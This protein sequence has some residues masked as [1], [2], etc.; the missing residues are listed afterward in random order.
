MAERLEEGG[1]SRVVERWRG[2][3]GLGKGE[4]DP[5]TPAGR[6]RTSPC[7]VPGYTSR[8]VARERR[9]PVADLMTDVPRCFPG[10]EGPGG[11]GVTP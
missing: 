8:G 2:G 10:G 4:R 6:T 7:G 1:A 11:R 3:W 9:V 5:T